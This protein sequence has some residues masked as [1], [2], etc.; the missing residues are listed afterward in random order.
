MKTQTIVFIAA[1]IAQFCILGAIAAQ[2]S[3]LLIFNHTVQLRVEPYDPATVLSGYYAHLTYEISRPIGLEEF[4]KIPDGTDIYT[5][6]V[7]GHDGVSEAVR[8]SLTPPDILGN[9]HIIRGRKLG[10]SVDYDINDR[11]ISEDKREEVDMGLRDR[12][13][14]RRAEVRLDKHGFPAL[15]HLRIGNNRY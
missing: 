5:V 2:K 9:E 3:A 13:A 7:A 10:S 6:I 4:D 15:H 14:D 12:S 8:M 11:Y 1:V